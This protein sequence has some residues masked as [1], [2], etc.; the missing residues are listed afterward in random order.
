MVGQ[1][2][3]HHDAP[4][5]VWALEVEAEVGAAVVDDVWLDFVVVD[6]ADVVWLDE[7]VVDDVVAAAVVWLPVAASEPNTPTPAT[8][9]AAT[10]AVT[11][12]ARRSRDRRVSGE[13]GGRGERAEEAPS[14]G[15]A[16]P[17]PVGPPAAEVPAFRA[18]IPAS[19]RLRL[20]ARPVLP[21]NL[22]GTAPGLAGI[23]R[24]R[25]S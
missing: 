3:Q 11:T 9:A 4:D 13:R 12:R 1:G 10:K 21:G 8:P 19:S 22:L 17:G 23:R 14:P 25:P 7:A 20:G 2:G 6:P 15:T 5:V 24:G 18:P 16:G